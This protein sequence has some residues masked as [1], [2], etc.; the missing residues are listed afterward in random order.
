LGSNFPVWR[1]EPGTQLVDKFLKDS[2]NDESSFA[3]LSVKGLAD[4]SARV[5]AILLL[6]ISLD[7]SAPWNMRVVSIFEN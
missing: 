1:K 6:P 2:M 7:G 4:A 5:L 3:G